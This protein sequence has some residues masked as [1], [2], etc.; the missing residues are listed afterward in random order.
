MYR[1]IFAHVAGSLI[2]LNCFYACPHVI[3]VCVSVCVLVMIVKPAKTAES[4]QMPFGGGRLALAE[5]PCIGWVVYMALS[6]EY[7]QTI[8]ARRRCGLLLTSVQQLVTFVLCEQTAGH[9]F[10][11]LVLEFTSK[12]GSVENHRSNSFEYFKCVQVCSL[13]PLTVNSISEWS[14]LFSACAITDYCH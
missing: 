7:D 6:G 2:D 13:A 9:V 8:R 5:E 14:G 10:R 1:F 12:A 11:Q 4:I 3:V